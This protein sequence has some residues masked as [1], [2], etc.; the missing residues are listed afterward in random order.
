VDKF[1]AQ[2]N[3]HRFLEGAT[4]FRKYGPYKAFCARRV[5]VNSPCILKN[6]GIFIAS[7][8]YFGVS[9]ALSRV[10]NGPDFGPV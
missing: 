7:T 8:S 1:S 5:S 10:S 3:S 6:L 9:T 2:L 4:F